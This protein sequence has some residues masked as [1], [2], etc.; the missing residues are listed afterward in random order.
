MPYNYICKNWD[1]DFIY[2]CVVL[3]SFGWHAFCH[4]INKR[5]WW[6][7]WL[8]L[9]LAIWTRL[10]VKIGSCHRVRQSQSICRGARMQMVTN[11]R[12]CRKFSFL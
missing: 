6:W 8:S 9:S 1:T 10:F 3:Y 4:V 12:C 7:W 5:I 11:W 2:S